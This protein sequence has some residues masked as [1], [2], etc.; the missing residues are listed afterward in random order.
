MNFITFT[1]KTPQILT[2]Q[3]SFLWNSWFFRKKT[4]HFIWH[5]IK[6][7]CYYLLYQLSHYVLKMSTVGKHTCVQLLAVIFHRVVNGF[8]QC[9]RPNQLKC[10]FKLKYCFWFLLQPVL[11]S[12]ITSKPD[13]PRDLG[14]KW[15]PL[16]FSNE[17]KVIWLGKT[18]NLKW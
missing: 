11:I 14:W 17:L 16:I 2:I 5:L 8:L 12:S 9:C 10:I 1:G 15:W 7:N 13:N 18:W 4:N 3:F 6:Y